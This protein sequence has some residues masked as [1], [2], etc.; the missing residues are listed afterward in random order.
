MQAVQRRSKVKWAMMEGV[1]IASVDGSRVTLLVPAGLARR[2]SDESNLSVLREALA[3]VVAGDW[4]LVVSPAV[5]DAPG[6][7]A[8]GVAGE[9]S[10]QP[11][12]SADGPPTR[13]VAP[14]RPA[15]VAAEPRVPAPDIAMTDDTVDEDGDAIEASS[16]TGAD[17]ETAAMELL[18]NSLGARPM[19]A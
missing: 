17:P 10:S 19:D 13:D 11:P 15:R 16:G 1:A 6:G 8:G 9:G 12:G 14:Q 4:Q 5:A 7:P 3:S 2:I 18:Q